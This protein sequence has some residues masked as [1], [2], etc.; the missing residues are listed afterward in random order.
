MTGLAAALLFLAAPDPLALAVP[1]FEVTGI[2]EDEG[3]YWATYFSNQLRKQ[4]LQVGDTP[5]PDA[6][7]KGQLARAG[8]SG[9][10][11]S[12]QVETPAGEALAAFSETAQTA[13]EIA[14]HFQKASQEFAALLFPRLGK[15]PVPQK[16]EPLPEPPRLATAGRALNPGVLLGIGIAAAGAAA[17]GVGLGLWVSAK[18]KLGAVARGE[19]ASYFA[20]E[21]QAAD[22]RLGSTISTAIMGA[23]GLLFVCGVLYSL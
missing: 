23:G 4:G 20:A 7:V 11:V 1:V 13:G 9:L 15:K 12:V 14:Y 19:P 18:D 22:A 10:Q 16:G 8:T 3:R 6:V 5:A 2:G 17:A 21:Q